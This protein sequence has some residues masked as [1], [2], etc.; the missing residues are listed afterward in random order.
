MDEAKVIHP[1]DPEHPGEQ[2][3]AAQGE[4]RREGQAVYSGRIAIHDLT[5]D[6]VEGPSVTG[7]QRL[8]SEAV[9]KVYPGTTVGVDLTR[10][11]R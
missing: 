2:V 1:G 4:E 3:R 6:F 8:I 11:D 7:L 9:E 10:T 5:G